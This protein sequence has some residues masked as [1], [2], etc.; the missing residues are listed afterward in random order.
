M[1]AS[2]Y[3]Y[4]VQED[5]GVYNDEWASSAKMEL[6]ELNRLEIAFLNAMVRLKASKIEQ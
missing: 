4:D 1:V 5:E 2:K 3:L 6:E